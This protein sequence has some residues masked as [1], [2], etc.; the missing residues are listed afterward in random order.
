MQREL[1]QW[2]GARGRLRRCTTLV[3]WASGIHS[4]QGC[5]PATTDQYQDKNGV[6]YSITTN[7]ANNEEL[8]HQILGLSRKRGRVI[9][10]TL[11][12]RLT[13]R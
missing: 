10:A 7:T 12:L 11:A 9:P 8:R 1:P 5:Q 4:G 3:V 13:T 6:S 2:L